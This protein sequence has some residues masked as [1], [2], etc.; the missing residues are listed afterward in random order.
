MIETHRTSHYL[1]LEA[2]GNYKLTDVSDTLENEFLAD[3]RDDPLTLILDIRNST[4]NPDEAEIIGFGEFLGSLSNRISG[5][6]YL[7]GD[8][9]RFG[10][11]NMVLVNGG[12]QDAIGRVK[13]SGGV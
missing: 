2:T 9:L 12:L 10:L 1:I 7:T 3:T 13:L 4:A 8:E 5:G 6:V 11:S